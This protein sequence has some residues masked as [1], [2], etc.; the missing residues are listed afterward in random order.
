MIRRSDGIVIYTGGH[1][2][3][4]NI[5]PNIIDIDDELEKFLNPA[6]FDEEILENDDYDNILN[7]WGMYKRN[8]ARFNEKY[9][10]PNNRY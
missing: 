8:E 4:R 9:F 2:I 3:V 6:D 5:N 7:L 10:K 1:S